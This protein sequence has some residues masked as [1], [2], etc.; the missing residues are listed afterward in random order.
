MVRGKHTRIA[1]PNSADLVVVE[2][3]G[4][5]ALGQ[6]AGA[7]VVT[8]LGMNAESGKVVGSG[9]IA[10]LG[11][12]ARFARLGQFAR[13]V[14]SG[15]VGSQITESGPNAGSGHGTGSSQSTAKVVILGQNDTSSKDVGPIVG[16]SAMVNVNIEDDSQEVSS[17][18]VNTVKPL[19]MGG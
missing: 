2:T 10:G 11:Q 15:Q 16:A 7:C 19:A 9:Q 3:S 1:S 17:D 13:F 18:Y 6:I 5:K 8:T 4:V 12:F 14:G